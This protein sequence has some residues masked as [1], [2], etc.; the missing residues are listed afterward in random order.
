MPERCLARL[1][2]Y[3]DLRMTFLCF[4]VHGAGV[5]GVVSI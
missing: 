5:G 4:F 3:L 2:G 1:N